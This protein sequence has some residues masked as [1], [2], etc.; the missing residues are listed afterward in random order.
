MMAIAINDSL[1]LL[2]FS[3]GVTH[4]VAQDPTQE[5]L[6]IVLRESNEMPGIEHRQWQAR[7]I[8]LST[9]LPLRLQLP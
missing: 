1:I 2:V 4:S 5:L 7:Q 3:F 9:V 8:A 6:L